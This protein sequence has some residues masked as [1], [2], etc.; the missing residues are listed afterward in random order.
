M[1]AKPITLSQAIEGHTLA[2]Y[3]TTFRRLETFLATDPPLPCQLPPPCVRN[4][5]VRVMSRF[6][7]RPL[8]APLEP[9]IAGLQP[10]SQ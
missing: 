9:G 6:H 1:D 10:G 3:D 4:P 5:G 2:G 7:G 8:S